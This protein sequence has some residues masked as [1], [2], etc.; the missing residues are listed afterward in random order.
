MSL[1]MAV[2]LAAIGACAA[3]TPAASAAPRSRTTPAAAAAHHVLVEAS[4][5]TRAGARLAGGRVSIRVT[6]P[7]RLER[8]TG[9]GWTTDRS[10]RTDRSG[11]VVFSVPSSAVP[12]AYRVTAPARKVVLSKRRGGDVVRRT[13]RLA[14]WTG[15]V[16]TVGGGGTPDAGQQPTQQPAQQPATTELL[17]VHPDGSGHIGAG[18]AEISASGRWVAFETNEDIAPLDDNGGWDVY[19]HD[20]ETG[21][22]ELASRTTSGESGAGASF[23]PR[24]S[25]DGRFVVFQSYAE[26]LASDDTNEASDVFIFDRETETVELVSRTATE[27]G[28]WHSGFADVSADGRYVV[29]DTMA[30]NLRP[31]TPSGDTQV[32]RV[33]RWT[34]EIRA[35]SWPYLEPASGSSSRPAISDDGQRVVFTSDASDLVARDD[36]GAPDVFIRDLA[37]WT[38]RAVSRAPS[39][40]TASGRSEEARISGDGST[41]AFTSDAFDLV[42]DD[43]NDVNDV[44]R[45]DVAQRQTSLLSRTPGGRPGNAGS[46][47]AAVSGD[48][49]AIAFV[50]IATDLSPGAGRSQIYLVE[51]G[52]PPELV[53]TGLSGLP[54]DGGAAYPSLGADGHLVAFR[55]DSGDLVP[56]TEAG[57]NRFFVRRRP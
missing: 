18:S 16:R 39:R 17:R 13:V 48:G 15:P 19:L 23:W 3:W 40:S 43:D 55:S 42:A 7:A 9:D 49:R 38:L 1:S 57:V 31:D 14:P 8:R 56:G 32:V 45:Y 28:S 53:S 6:R 12:V 46:H 20:R 11:R 52:R 33:D 2:L 44:F 41:V 4:V 21:A 34:G 50:S 35:V 26:D 5:P 36:N 22:T 47:G 54:G 37:T 27:V 10:S 24:I 30:D 51:S 25:P 29:F